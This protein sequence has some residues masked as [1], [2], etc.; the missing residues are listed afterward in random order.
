M[1][2]CVAPS[3]LEYP[4]GRG[5]S[6]HAFPR[7]PGRAGRF[8]FPSVPL[9][10]VSARRSGRAPS[11][12]APV[13]PDERYFVVRGRL[14]RRSNPALAADERERLVHALMHAR[15]GVRDALALGDT[16]ALRAAR[17]GVQAAKVAL[18]ERGPVWWD[19]GAPDWNRHLAKNTPYAAW[20]AAVAA[21]D[22]PV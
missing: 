11:A 15:R 18:G 1:V 16:G 19:D 14:W 6:A 7:A 3:D 13:T 10:H 12:A 2:S 21:G 17:A 8:A 5:P 9:R 4:A 20:W 22:P